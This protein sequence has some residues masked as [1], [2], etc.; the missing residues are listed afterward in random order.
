[1][2]CAVLG[3]EDV[4]RVQVSM[5]KGSADDVPQLFSVAV[6]GEALFGS[7]EVNAHRDREPGD[8]LQKVDD[9]REVRRSGAIVSVARVVKIVES[10]EMPA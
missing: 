9:G 3:E 2:S 6:C 5:E 10:D 7:A 1:M 8:F 4:L